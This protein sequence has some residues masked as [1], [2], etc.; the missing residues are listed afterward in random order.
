MDMLGF[1]AGFEAVVAAT[2]RGFSVLDVGARWG[3]DENE[4]LGVI[5]PVPLGVARFDGNSLMNIVAELGETK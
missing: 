1:R 5:E 4:G 3:V 2:R